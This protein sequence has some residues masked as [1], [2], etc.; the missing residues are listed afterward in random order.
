MV[1]SSGSL[2]LFL[3]PHWTVLG[4]NWT[5]LVKN[6]PWTSR[7]HA[8]LSFTIWFFITS[9]T[10]CQTSWR[11]HTS[12]NLLMLN[13]CCRFFFFFF[14]S[15]QLC[16]HLL[17][18]LFQ[19]V[20]SPSMINLSSAFERKYHTFSRSTTHLIW[21]VWSNLFSLLSDWTTFKNFSGTVLH[22]S[23]LYFHFQMKD[24][25]FNLCFSSVNGIYFGHFQLT[26]MLITDTF[27]LFFFFPRKKK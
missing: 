4:V 1:T 21:F 2:Q 22:R 15:S 19:A 9:H 24:Y 27:R 26:E 25:S 20:H 14:F 17:S 10:R 11:I 8:P 13:I 7:R 12:R 6:T 16:M 23:L 5:W 18:H 3:H